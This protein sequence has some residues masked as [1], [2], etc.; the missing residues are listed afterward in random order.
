M[1]FIMDLLR[2]QPG[3]QENINLLLGE[4]TP[5]LHG[6]LVGGNDRPANSQFLPSLTRNQI[7]TISLCVDVILVFVSFII[8]ERVYVWYFE[9]QYQMASDYTLVALVCAST[10]YLVALSM[11]DNAHFYSSIIDVT[12]ALTLSFVLVLVLGFALKLSEMHSRIWIVL[13]FAL[14]LGFLCIKSQAMHVLH[15]SKRLGLPL[16]ES[17][18][19]YG[20][21]AATLKEALQ[22]GGDGSCEVRVYDINEFSTLLQ[23]GLDNKFSRI[24]LCV[25]SNRMQHIKDLFTAL[26]CL[27]V[28]IDV[29][30]M[31]NDMEGLVRDFHISPARFL[32]NLDDGGRNEWGMLFKRALDFVLSA[33]VLL[34]VSPLMAATAIAIKWNDGGPVFFRQRR[35]GCNHCVISVWKFRTMNVREDGP[36]VTQ[37]TRNDPRVTKIGK[38]LRR[39][40]IDELP[41]L[42]NVLSGEMSLVGPRPHA[43]AH[44]LYYS[45]LISSYAVRHKVKP[46]I[47][48]WAQVIGLRG[49]SEEISAM[50][51]RAAADRWYIRNWSLLLDL[52]ILVMTPFVLL[53]RKN[54]Y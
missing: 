44:N 21:G 23:D 33:I 26:D 34:A 19:I 25:P 45:E 3:L 31:S 20:S 17:I 27:P 22:A 38:F 48:G 37:A 9:N 30:A 15:K 41:Q 1:G 32:I 18:A 51:E 6:V 8:S 12:K 13:S 5:S 24:I 10:Y 53:T 54:A 11:R 35:H 16:V 4:N 46:G 40:S 47:T 36:V 29:W 49:N 43:V 50:I 52:K 39:T 14:A 2:E 42:F 28:R 7:A